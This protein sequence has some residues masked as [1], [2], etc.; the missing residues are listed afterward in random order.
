MKKRIVSIVGLLFLSVFACANFN[1]KNTVL[2]RDTEI[3][4]ELKDEDAFSL[5]ER[6][7]KQQDFLRELQSL[8]GFNYRVTNSYKYSTNALKIDVSSSS[9]DS[10]GSLDS[11]KKV[12]K[13]KFY[14]FND[15]LSETYQK[16]D[17][18]VLF[19]STDTD[20]KLSTNYSKSQMNV[21]STNNGG[22]NTIVAILDSS[23]SL[24]H[25]AFSGSI[26][27]PRYSKSEMDNKVTTAGFHG[28]PNS[29]HSTY[30][31]DKI[32]FYYDYGGDKESDKNILVPDYDV[33]SKYSYHGNHVASIAAGNGS[34]KGIAPNAQ[35]A[36]M[37]VFTTYADKNGDAVVGA[38]DEAVLNALEDCA[39]IGVDGINLS[40]GTDLDDFTSESVSFDVIE[41]LQEKGTSVNISAGNNGRE[42]FKDAGAY[43][44]SS[45]SSVETG[46]LGSYANSSG[47]IIASGNLA[48][49]E[50]LSASMFVGDSSIYYNDQI[51][52]HIGKDDS[53]N[54][55]VTKYAK[56]LPFSSLIPNN[57]EK[58]SLDYVVV[59][60]Y[61]EE[62]DY[63]DL[64]VKD[65]VAVV[66]RGSST[67]VDKVNQ[68]SKHGAAAC[69][70]Y[71]KADGSS[72]GWM[73]LDGVSDADLIPVASVNYSAIKAFTKAG[74]DKI[75]IK[76]SYASDYSSDGA[77]YDLRMAPSIM[78]PGQNVY[79]AVNVDSFGNEDLTSYNYLSGTS[80]AAPNYT[81]AEALI[82]GER[83]YANE[84]ERM[85]YAKTIAMRAMSTANPVQ[86]ANE[87]F[88]SPRKQGAGY[89]DVQ[90]AINSKVYLEGDGDKAKIELKN[91]SEVSKGH[92]KFDVKVHNEEK[93]SRNY[94]A[95]LFVQV[96]E[97]KSIEDNEFVGVNA[98]KVVT[99]YDVTLE[100]FTFDIQIDSNSESLIS[101]DKTISDQ[102]KKYLDENF[103]NGTYL[104]GYLIL[105]SDS[106]TDLSIP[107]LGFYG[108]YGS[109]RCVE[110]FSFEKN[111]EKVY[112][113]DL[114]NSTLSTQSLEK[115]NYES[116]IVVS[117]SDFT[118]DQYSNVLYNKAS[119]SDYGNYATYNE[120]SK[121]IFLGISGS[122]TNAVIQQYVNC[123]VVDNKITMTN[124]DTGKVVLTD[125][126]F[127]FVFGSNDEK[128]HNL[129][130]SMINSSLI[131][132]KIM[133]DRAYTVL[134]FTND[135]GKL[136]YPEGDYEFKTEYE[137]AA[138]YTQTYIYNVK[139]LSSTTSLENSL[140]STSLISDNGKD[141]MHIGFGGSKPTNVSVNGTNVE[142]KSSEAGYYIDLPYN[143]YESVESLVLKITNT[144]GITSTICVNKESIK[145]SGY[146]V[147]SSEILNGM[148]INL[149]TEKISD[150]S[151][152]DAYK[153]TFNVKNDKGK[154]VSFK[155][156]AAYHF[157]VPS[158]YLETKDNIHIYGMD[159]AGN[160]S[161]EET[162]YTISSDG[163]LSVS[164]GNGIFKVVYGTATKGN[165]NVP[166]V[167]VSIA[168]SVIVIGILVFVGYKALK[169]K[170]AN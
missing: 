111:D 5:E 67:F 61:G 64:D 142:Y 68:A 118:A 59:P 129:H 50:G 21:P 2:N 84:E 57:E 159:A 24:N 9:V 46:V 145:N 151:G 4:V 137:L 155:R 58:V 124:K 70:I 150:S 166:L 144:Y 11:V 136:I 116:M 48:A 83:T 141:V 3:I 18:G 66:A 103:E 36:M 45:S 148:T 80:M 38:T 94:N 62:K 107:Y 114:L 87:A 22:A 33:F 168:A 43:V 133:A 156:N 101:V 17:D 102:A 115:G 146:S 6:E 56:Q 122:S 128:Q 119:F 138:G 53:G 8:V 88:Y 154:D 1:N 55:V 74:V 16:T 23:F 90:D 135:S 113:S 19:N 139:L 32:P 49:D 161:I 93:V 40:L 157:V 106:S 131:E 73:I 20:T 99:P 162:S 35:I 97:I 127:S 79:G 47:M 167:V 54:E 158:E 78:T 108:D 143:N 126:M 85:E 110:E 72:F 98:T 12:A 13:N 96:P 92:L 91:N 117:G 125:A 130:K 147:S 82:L 42:S 41:Q 76:K 105:N 15:L 132:S 149:N 69:I 104:E 7:K 34:Y 170:K 63:A 65:K 77:T 51:V 30:Y 71:N 121:T 39:I 140:T 112:G 100:K 89:L 152:Y 31:N 163:M 44:Y 169:K 25:D 165:V 134:K 37:K 120:N 164:S 60:N 153:Y 75:T 28:K 52:D 95:T 86:Q 109:E 10:I 27:N 26:S 14:S 29:T 123:S 160:V 81:G